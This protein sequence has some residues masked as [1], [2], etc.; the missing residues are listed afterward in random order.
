[1]KYEMICCENDAG[2]YRVRYT[3]NGPY[4]TK[5]MLGGYVSSQNSL[6][7][8]GCCCVL[9]NAHVEDKSKV[10]DDAIIKDNA[11]LKQNVMM[12]VSMIDKQVKVLGSFDVENK[13]DEICT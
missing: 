12:Y 11:K 7:Q 5:G 9:D 3:S 13:I 2:M 6:S 1:M 4:W 10:I 8:D